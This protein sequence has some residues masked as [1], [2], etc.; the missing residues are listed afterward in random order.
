[1]PK[2]TAIMNSIAQC[3]FLCGLWGHALAIFGSLITVL[4]WAVSTHSAENTSKASIP[5]S[6][7][8]FQSKRLTA[9]G[10]LLFT[11]TSVHW[12]QLKCTWHWD[13]GNPCFRNTN[14]H[15]PSG[16][17]YLI[18]LSVFSF[19]AFSWWV[20]MQKNINDALHQV[21]WCDDSRYIGHITPLFWVEIC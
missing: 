14:L 3:R 5:H 19:S 20:H 6:P 4:K 8:A 17:G 18:C 11:Y 12:L 7:E 21:R 2:H 13:P 10:T 9:P 16:F 1:M 15:R